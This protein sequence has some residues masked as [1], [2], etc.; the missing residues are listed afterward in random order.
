[1]LQFDGLVAAI[2]YSQTCLYW[3]LLKAAISELSIM[4]TTDGPSYTNQNDLSIVAK[5]L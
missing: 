1:M 5:I 3:S 2:L 4:V